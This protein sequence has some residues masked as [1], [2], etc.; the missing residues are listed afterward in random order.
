MTGKVAVLWVVFLAGLVLTVTGVISSV[1]A[2]CPRP[3]A[4]FPEA[5]AHCT[6]FTIITAL[7]TVLA[8]GGGISALAVALFEDIRQDRKA[9]GV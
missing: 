3:I 8:L 4:H 7:G 9:G 2:G 1:T 6:A 5:H